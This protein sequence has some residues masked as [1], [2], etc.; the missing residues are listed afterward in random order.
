MSRLGMLAALLSTLALAACG[1]ADRVTAPALSVYGASSLKA[2]LPSLDDAATY[3]FAG[4]DTLAAQIEAGAPADVLI[5][6]SPTEPEALRAQG[7]CGPGTPIAS[8]AL[9]LVVPRTAPLVASLSD[10]AEGGHPL[11]LG[12]PD[13]PVGAYARTA[14]AALGL[15]GLLDVNPVSEERDAAAIVAKVALGGAHAGVAYVTDAAASDD[16]RAIPLPAEV[17]PPITYVACPVLRDGVPTAGAEA[18]IAMLASER[19]Q[20]ALRDAGFG[21]VP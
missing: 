5:A 21:P 15:S 9:A 13:V 19:G 16:V 3:Q 8:N 12:G 18:Y 10:L 14:L 6:A 11:A 4:S 7:L 1:G 20:Q 2:V 17:Q